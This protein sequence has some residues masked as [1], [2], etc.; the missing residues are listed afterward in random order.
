[1]RHMVWSILVVGIFGFIAV[2]CSEDSTT[3]DP[4]PTE[5]TVTITNVSQKGTLDVTRADGI[6]PLSGGAYAVYTGNNP[7]FTVGGMADAGMELI[8]EDGAAQTTVDNLATI[9]RVSESGSFVGEANG[10][11][12]L[13]SAMVSFKVI[14]FPGDRLQFATMFVQ[15]NDWFYAFEGNG[16]DLFNGDTP[17]SGDVTSS[18]RLYDAGTEEDTAPGTGPD[19]KPA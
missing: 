12:I 10:G 11:A 15:S 18:L 6:V 17:I 1:M 5:F 3:Q 16:I 7:M 14:A 13:P 9:E 19:Q 4:T 8:A 2:G